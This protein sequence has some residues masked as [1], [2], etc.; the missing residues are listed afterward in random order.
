MV[1]LIF[2][3][4]EWRF[5]CLSTKGHVLAAVYD[6]G[7]AETLQTMYNALEAQDKDIQQQDQQ[8]QEMAE[9]GWRG[10]DTKGGE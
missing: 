2:D 7:N 5:E 1:S 6:K 9:L 4:K 3:E 10:E 8:E